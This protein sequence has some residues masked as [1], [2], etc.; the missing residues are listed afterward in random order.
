MAQKQAP[1]PSGTPSTVGAMR[2]GP[3]HL[4]DG[5]GP[6]KGTITKRALAAPIQPQVSTTNPTGTTRRVK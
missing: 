6:G 2:G 5:I 3:R 4:T 1:I